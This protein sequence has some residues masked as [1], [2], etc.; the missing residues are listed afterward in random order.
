M[1][2]SGKRQDGG[3]CLG[4]EGHGLAWRWEAQEPELDESVW[5]R[6]GRLGEM[7]VRGVKAMG[8]GKRQDKGGLRV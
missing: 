1:G 6:R 2:G 3:R 4:S 5:R 7:V 8:S